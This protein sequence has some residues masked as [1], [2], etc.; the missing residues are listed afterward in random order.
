MN[1]NLS[2]LLI[3]SILLF[4]CTLNSSQDIPSEEN[5][6]PLED[7]PKPDPTPD[8]LE[9]EEEQYDFEQE[10]SYQ[11]PEEI[12]LF[13]D[14]DFA[15]YDTEEEITSILASYSI[16]PRYTD[17]QG[18][19]IS[20]EDDTIFWESLGYFTFALDKFFSD[21]EVGSY[22]ETINICPSCTSY[23]N[24]GNTIF[25]PPADSNL[26]DL[27]VIYSIH[28]I[29]HTID[30]SV[31]SDSFREICWERWNGEWFLD[32]PIIK[33]EC[34][35]F[36]QAFIPDTLTTTAMYNTDY[37]ESNLYYYSATDFKEDFAETVTAY[38]ISGEKF[39][40][41]A[42]EWPILKQKYD[43]IKDNVFNGKEF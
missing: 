2:L 12:E 13:T 28:E 14:E 27:Y 33:E 42:E 22:L 29:S 35:N 4:G 11:S 25:M 34:E 23:T 10:D 5:T 18:N 41:L 24:W 15:P 26:R 8:E 3:F 7:Q 21:T 32:H 20:I 16:T 17:N 37:E 36:E 39:R 43:W 30:L 6:K 1:K 31:D 19:E 9:Q 38:I 40:E